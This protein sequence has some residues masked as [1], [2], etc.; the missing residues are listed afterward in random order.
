KLRR[1]GTLRYE[2]IFVRKNG[3]NL[4]VEVSVTAIRGGYFQAILRDISQRKKSEALLA[5]EKR[6]LEMIATGVGLKEILDTVC[7]I[8]GEQRTGPL[9]CVLLL[10]ADGVP[11][12][13]IPAA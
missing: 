1:G 12:E 6:L 8:I 13:C 4:P 2:R 3:D 7:L 11:V 10:N 9:A 5:G